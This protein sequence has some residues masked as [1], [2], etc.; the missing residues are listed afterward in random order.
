MRDP[1]VVSTEQPIAYKDRAQTFEESDVT[2]SGDLE[3]Q[4]GS[5]RLPFND[6]L[7][8][9]YMDVTYASSETGTF[10]ID[11]TDRY[12]L[13]I[14]VSLQ[15]APADGYYIDVGNI[16]VADN[17]QPPNDSSQSYNVDVSGLTGTT[18][19]SVFVDDS[20]ASGGAE[21]TT[22]AVAKSR[23]GSVT[24]EWPTPED[25]YRWDAGTYSASSDGETVAVYV[26]ENDGSGWTQIAGPI[27]R[28]QTITAAPSSQMRYRIELSR[29]DERNNPTLD[30]I[31]RRWVV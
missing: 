18:T 17:I 4:N 19:V 14:D 23:N 26:E 15:E 22:E 20:S 3:L 27:D 11:L 31:Y 10:D 12:D 16:D 1:P 8:S 2:V 25:V 13:R 29:S 9:I 6:V 24:V 21:V 30:A 7:N 28:G 5:F